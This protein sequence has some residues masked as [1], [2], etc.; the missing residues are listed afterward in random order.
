[1]HWVNTVMIKHYER[2]LR[3]TGD[4]ILSRTCKCVVESKS[5]DLT[6]VFSSIRKMTQSGHEVDFDEIVVGSDTHT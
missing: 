4:N 1:M 6:R 5:G 3:M 2:T